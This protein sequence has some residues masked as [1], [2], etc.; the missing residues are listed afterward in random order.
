[1]YDNNYYIMNSNT[2]SFNI[3]KQTI[4]NIYTFNICD[5]SYLCFKFL[6]NS[7]NYLDNI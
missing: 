1:M 2:Y 7:E 3:Y 4:D 6:E 5:H